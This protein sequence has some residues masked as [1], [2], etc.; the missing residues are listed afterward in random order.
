MRG[1]SRPA[2]DCL[3]CRNATSSD[4]ASQTAASRVRHR[5][6]RCRALRL[7]LRRT[8][9]ATAT[10]TAST[11][12]RLAATGGCTSRGATQGGRQAARRPISALRRHFVGR[13]SNGD[14]CIA[15]ARLAARRE[16]HVHGRHA[17]YSGAS[18]QTANQCCDVDRGR[19]ER[20]QFLLHQRRHDWRHDDSCTCWVQRRIQRSKLPDGQSVRCDVDFVGR[21]NNGNFYCINGGTIGTTD[22]ACTGCNAGYRGT[23]CQTAN[24]CSATQSY[25]DTGSNGNFYCI[26][27]GTIGGTTGSCT[28]TGCN[29]GYSGALP[30]GQSVRCDVDFVGRRERRNFYCING[31]TIGG[32]TGSCACTGCTSPWGGPHCE[33]NGACTAMTRAATGSDARFYCINGGTIGT[34]GSC[35]CTG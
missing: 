2:A 8:T 24:Q 3:Q 12:A 26:N 30:D 14:F 16:A 22:A 4:S 20:R 15:A 28:C 29:A 13:R 10:F 35:T 34:T 18:C 23:H 31:G 7:R 21:R 25:L 6:H 32:T 19:R 9:G 1:V 5:R 17:G 11:A 33:P 27:G